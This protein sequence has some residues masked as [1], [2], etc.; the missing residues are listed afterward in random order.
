[1]TSTEVVEHFKSPYENWQ[2]L[3]DLVSDDGVLGVMTQFYSQEIKYQDW[4]YKN[5]PTHVCFYSQ[6]TFEYIAKTFKFNIVYNDSK[7]VI[8]FKK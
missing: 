1:V 6:K 2:Q 5:D 3:T 7:S 4:W 8:I